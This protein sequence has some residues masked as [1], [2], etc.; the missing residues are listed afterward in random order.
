MGWIIGIYIAIGIY[1]TLLKFADPNPAR[2]PVWMLTNRAPK[3]LILYSS[4]YVLL[5]PLIRS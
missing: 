2:K 5:W 4:L 3:S 1:K